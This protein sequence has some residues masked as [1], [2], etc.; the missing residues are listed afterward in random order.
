MSYAKQPISIAEKKAL[1]QDD[2][3]QWEPRDL[4]LH[5]LRRIDSGE[6]FD[7]MIVT[8]VKKSETG[9]CTGM[10]RAKLK[11]LEC[12]GALEAVKS[13]LIHS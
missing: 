6:S 12:I 5:F 3:T 13:D 4:L 1:D 2:C 8:Y 10:L 7:G 9:S 11:F